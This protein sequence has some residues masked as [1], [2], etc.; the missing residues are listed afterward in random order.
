V[1]RFIFKI[2]INGLAIFL[3]AKYILN[4]NFSVSWTKLA[5]AGLILGVINYIIK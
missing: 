3:I 1:I 4:L 2:F 5:L